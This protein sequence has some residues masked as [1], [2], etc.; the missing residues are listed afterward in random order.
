MSEIDPEISALTQELP[1]LDTQ[2]TYMSHSVHVF[3]P[4]GFCQLLLLSITC[5]I[6]MP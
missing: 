1:S 3:F 6:A 5:S 4:A 2:K